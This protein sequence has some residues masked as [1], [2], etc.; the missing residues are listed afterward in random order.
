LAKYADFESDWIG[1]PD[2]DK[3]WLQLHFKF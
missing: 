3:F 2:V 1:K